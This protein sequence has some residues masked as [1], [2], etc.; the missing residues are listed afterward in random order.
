MDP[1]L[2]PLLTPLL[3][4]SQRALGT[5]AWEPDMALPEAHSGHMAKR[6]QKG[7]QKGSKR[8]P[9]GV[10]WGSQETLARAPG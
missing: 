8:G 1:L 4:V 7:V 9:K 2:D 10:I 5:L 3:G 6:G